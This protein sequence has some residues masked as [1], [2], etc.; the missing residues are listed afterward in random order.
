MPRSRRYDERNFEITAVSS[1]PAE[2]L[3]PKPN[4]APSISTREA[5]SGEGMV[6]WQVALP[7]PLQ[8]LF[9][10]GV[11]NQTPVQAGIRVQVPLGKGQR[12]GVLWSP[13]EKE[14]EWVIKPVLSVLDDE[15]LL[16]VELLACLGWAADYYHFPL[17]ETV[18]AALAPRLRQG[19]SLR[20]MAWRILPSGEQALVEGT[21]RGVRQRALLERI[22]QT[23]EGVSESRLRDFPKAVRQRLADMGLI[24]PFEQTVSW[25]WPVR[26]D[27][28]ANTL[29][30]PTLNEAQSAAVTEVAASLDRFGV[31]LLEGVTGS[32]KTEVYL[33][34]IDQVLAQGRQVMILVPE[35]A[36][37][38]QL[39][40]RFTD[41]L[42]LVP[43]VLHSGLNDGDRL[44]AWLAAR[45]GDAKVVIGT[46]SAV[47]QPFAD[48]GLIVVDEEHDGSFKQSEGFGY[49]ARD[50]AIWRARRLGVPIMLG[51]ATPSLESL[52][53]VSL[54]R[55]H[56]L[57]LPER[58]GG[59][60][61]PDIR[62][63]D[64][65]Q[66]R[67]RG[68]LSDE[69]A[70]AIETH[71]LA[72]GQVMLYLNRRGYASNLLCHACGWVAECPHCDSFMTWHRG[73]QRLRCHHCGFECQ[74]PTACPSCSTPLSPRGLGTEQL[75][76]VLTGLF[77]G[78]GI[79]RLDRDALSRV[80]ELD[81]RL[82][83]IQSGEARL[84]VGTQIL[85]KGH[86]FPHVSLVAVVDADQ[87]LFANDFRGAERFAQQLIQVAGRAGRASR[88]G[89]VLVQTHQPEHV[90]LNRLILAGY[91]SFAQTLLAERAE[92]GLPPVRAAAL[93]RAD[94]RDVD[95]PRDLLTHMADWLHQYHADPAD[96]P[97]DVWGPVPAPLARRA[98]R[99][100]YQLLI[101]ADD[102]PR[103]HAALTQL[104]SWQGSRRT[105]GIRWSI[106]VDPVDMA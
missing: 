42:G 9:T 84:I 56:L 48:L 13:A 105:K 87:A 91:A 28:S 40:T 83:S 72:G 7:G 15:P 92:A 77:P 60:A 36:L 14:A 25:M 12:M 93:I 66:Q 94:A 46:R 50:V 97:L 90:G 95:A 38:P 1:A 59:A 68:G 103:L 10:Y 22:A 8:T 29:P 34:L 106:D 24:E 44:N 58:A 35:I 71:L 61:M 54:G 21:L 102:R 73:A 63:L 51:S 11:P 26:A 62:L 4:I 57:T 45:S 65:R 69:L 23:P 41:R 37:T 98:G 79:E 5:S 85:V 19:Q 99:Y 33:N 6:Y 49:H 20:G 16:D 70:A 2:H 96:S 47:F 104:E 17:G 43:A 80:G 64:V 52:R 78:F 53:N 18:L 82:A 81:R 89:T 30:A 88:A 67:M 32:G 75:E 3:M 31:W 27:T 74:P 55:Y 86:D 100:R 76:D 39:V 101:L